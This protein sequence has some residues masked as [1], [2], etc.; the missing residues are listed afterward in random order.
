MANLTVSDVMKTNLKTMYEDEA[1]ST[2]DWEMSLDE[3]RHIL[4]VDGRGKLVGILTDRDVLRAARDL[5]DR[6]VPIGRIMCRD[7]LTIGP[8]APASTAVERMLRGRY[9]ALPVVDD[10]GHPI[11]IVT[12]TDFLEVAYRA[13]T[14]LETRAPAR[15]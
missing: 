2:A 9:S 4:V 12:S 11:G 10:Q 3:I 5:G 6:E 14:G 1:V 15:A 8:T 7:V 13:L